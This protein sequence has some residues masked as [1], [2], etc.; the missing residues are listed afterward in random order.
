MKELNL[1]DVYRRHHPNSKNVRMTLKIKKIEVQ[2][3]FLH[4]YETIN[5]SSKENRNTN[6][7]RNRSKS[8]K[9]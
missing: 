8:R 4:N 1:V 7:N 6:F 9:P 2:N 5:Q 3:R